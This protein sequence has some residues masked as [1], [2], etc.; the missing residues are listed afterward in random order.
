MNIV[1]TSGTGSRILP[2]DIQI[3]ERVRYLNLNKELLIFTYDEDWWANE[4]NKVFPTF[5]K[6]LGIGKTHD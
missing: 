2:H 5:L 6:Q 1:G 4:M 3:Q